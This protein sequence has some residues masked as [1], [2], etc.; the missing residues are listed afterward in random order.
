MQKVI[1]STAILAA[2]VFSFVLTSAL[3]A[4]A[5]ATRVYSNRGTISGIDL[6]H[7]TIVVEVP[8]RGDQMTVGGPLVKGAKLMKNGQPVQL[9]DFKDGESVWVKWQYTKTGLYIL[10]VTKK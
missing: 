2:V 6:N 5:A 7:D 10:D 3:A 8:V 4:N 1:R 9:K